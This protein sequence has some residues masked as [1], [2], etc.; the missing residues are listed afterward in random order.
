[1]A[2]KKTEKEYIIDP[3]V[4][5]IIAVVI[6]IGAAGFVYQ[7]AG[8]EKCPVVEFTVDKSKIYA[9]EMISFNNKTPKVKS[10]KWNFGDGAKSTEL[11]PAHIYKK[12]GKYSIELTVNGSCYAQKEVIVTEKPVTKV[13]DVIPRFDCPTGV[14]VGENVR[15]TC[16]NDDATSY[17]W[18]FGDSKKVDSRAK[19]PTHKYKS[20]GT[21]KIT[22]VI[23]GNKKFVSS[24]SIVVSKKENRVERPR[25]EPQRP[26]VV[27]KPD[28][29]P[30]PTPVVV[31]VEKPYEPISNE[32]F[33][34]L[35]VD[36]SRGKAGEDKIYYHLTTRS[37]IFNVN[38][39]NMSCSKFLS[40]VKGKELVITEMD[41]YKDKTTKKFNRVDLK[42]K[43]LK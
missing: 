12:P 5:R 3:I 34:K 21:Y 38:S 28:P 19:N 29:T 11:S 36:Y 24:K 35:L 27:A 37:V 13:K 31:P 41:S 2:A 32:E 22:L 17:E 40:L 9:G 15:F 14:T 20:V 8:Y 10:S 42:I 7:W 6:F 39:E 18:T 43:K 26:P 33:K 4:V 1:M 16:E 23:N 30:A 25:P